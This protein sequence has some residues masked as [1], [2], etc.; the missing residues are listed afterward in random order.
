M[1]GFVSSR[2]EVIQSMAEEPYCVFEINMKNG[3]SK[4]LYLKKEAKYGEYSIDIC[5]CML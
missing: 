4:I 1:T 5:L 3:V 2:M